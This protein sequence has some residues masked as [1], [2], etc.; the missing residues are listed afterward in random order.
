MRAPR[1]AYD[2]DAVSLGDR[3]EDLRGRNR[4][5]RWRGVVCCLVPE[6][7]GEVLEPGGR[8]EDQHAGRFAVDGEGRGGSVDWKARAST[9]AK[10]SSAS[11]AVTLAVNRPP[12][13]QTDTPSPALKRKGLRAADSDT[14][15][16]SASG[17][18]SDTGRKRSTPCSGQLGVRVTGRVSGEA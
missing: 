7:E 5:V 12:S 18:K 1:G 11:A 4:Q 14:C 2:L 10:R 13:D 16:P 3:P 15:L 9:R 8:N 6:F 17:R